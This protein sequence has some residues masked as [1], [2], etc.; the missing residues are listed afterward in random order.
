MYG[1]LEMSSK[2]IYIQLSNI[3]TFVSPKPKLYKHL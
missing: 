3:Q 2:D 1:A